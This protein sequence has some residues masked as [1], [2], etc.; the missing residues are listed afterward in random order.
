ML[1]IRECI[2]EDHKGIYELNKTEMGYDYP[3]EK[4]REKIEKLLKSNI[5]RIFVAVADNKVVGYI[6]LNDYDTIYAPHMKN[7]MGIAVAGEYKRQG[8]G[9]K[10]MERAEKWAKETGAE[11]IRLVSGEKRKEAHEFYRKCGFD[12]G[13]RQLN[14]K[15]KI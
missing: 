13:R 12:E 11:A 3:I 15:K 14:F 6:H 9:K 1:K 8:I 5:D 4:T 10:L 7:V 2:I